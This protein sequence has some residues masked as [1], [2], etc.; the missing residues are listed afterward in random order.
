M[1]R[2]NAQIDITAKNKTQ[3]AFDSVNRNLT[4]MRRATNKTVGRVAKI[5]TAFVAAGAAATAAMVK[6]RMQAID[7]LAKTAD[8]LGVTTEALA[9]F[10]HAAELSGVSTQ[11]FDKALQNMGVQIANAAQGTGIATRALDEL[12]LNAQALTKLPLDQQMREVAKAMESVEDHSTRTRIAYELFGARGVGVLNMMKGGADAMD[13]MAQEAETLG[14]ALD[15]VDAAQIEAAND[16][17]TRAKSVFEGFANQITVALSPAISELAANFYQT[18]LDTNEMGNVG[19]RVAKLM[20]KGFG[21][22]ADGILGLK[23]LVKGIQLAFARLTALLL[24]GFSKIG[25]AVDFIIRQYN[26]V[27]AFFG[28]PTLAAS[29]SK[30]FE[31][32]AQSFSSVGDDIQ[33]QISDALNA[34]LPSERINEWYDN[35]QMRAR[36]TAEVVAANAPGV[37][38]A[39]ASA[40]AAPVD[41]TDTDPVTKARMEGE[42]KLKEFTRKSTM[43]QTQIVLGGLDQQLAGIAKHNKAAFALQ[44]GVQIAQ[45]V[46]NTYTGATKALASFPPPINFAMAA[47]VVASGLAQVASIRAQSFE[48]GGF[49]GFGARSGGVDGKGGFPAILHPNETVID[50][51]KSPRGKQDDEKVRNQSEV[52]VHQ[53]INVTT[54]IQSTVRAEIANMLPAITEAAKAAVADSRMRGGGFSAAMGT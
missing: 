50:H 32:M 42:Q 38:A 28:R 25:E 26:K 2:M 12:G 49:T 5:G 34:P 13:A 21:F 15:R 46:M 27:A 10:R 52:I 48:G 18:A 24:Q 11:V 23:L 47:A 53:T 30:N 3:K 54:G 4:N 43:E 7:N 31:M 41:V 44:K 17:V 8:K 16:N 1:S 19:D 29:V 37:V 9:G 45:A 33:Q 14:I 40:A 22:V 20:V 36:K 35:V 6:M 39:E 51:T